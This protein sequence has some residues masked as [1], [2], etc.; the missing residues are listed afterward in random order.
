MF[1]K[2]VWLF[3]FRISRVHGGL[4]VSRPGHA[5]LGG[6]LAGKQ[7]QN[8]LFGSKS[9]CW[10]ELFTLLDFGSLLKMPK[11]HANHGHTRKSILHAAK[12]SQMQ[13]TLKK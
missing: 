4:Q 11:M 7:K 3:R 9:S 6:A 1:I 2:H 5:K 8:I 13:Y 12:S 10:R